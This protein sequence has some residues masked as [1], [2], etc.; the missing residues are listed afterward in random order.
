MLTFSL[1]YARSVLLWKWFNN[2]ENQL[3][4][5]PASVETGAPLWG[6][7]L[8]ESFSIRFH[9]GHKVLLR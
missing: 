7:K 9:V 1:R 2:V 4:L 3:G 6:S 8:A 5:S